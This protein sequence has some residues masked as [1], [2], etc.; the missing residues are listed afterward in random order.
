MEDQFAKG[1]DTYTFSDKT[2]LD[3]YKDKPVAY[4]VRR[5]ATALWKW[6][7]NSGFSMR[8]IPAALA[9]PGFSDAFVQRTDTWNDEE[10]AGTGR[11]VKINSDPTREFVCLRQAP[12]FKNDFAVFRVIGGVHDLFEHSF[13]QNDVVKRK[14][15]LRRHECL[16]RQ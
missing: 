4:R 8:V 14:F 10:L 1:K 7:P 12:I 15:R 3:R 2:L 5:S 16:F 11:T 13:R 6:N 9:L